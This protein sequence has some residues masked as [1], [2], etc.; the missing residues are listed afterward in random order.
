MVVDTGEDLLRNA[1]FNSVAIGIDHEGVQAISPGVDDSLAIDRTTATDQSLTRM[2]A[3]IKP[4]LV[5]VDGA[6]GEGV[7]GTE[8]STDHFEEVGRTG[9]KYRRLRADRSEE[10][11]VDAS[12]LAQT[13]DVHPHRLLQHRLVCRE[14]RLPVRQVQKN[15][16]CGVAGGKEMVVHGRHLSI[17]ANPGRHAIGR[18]ESHVTV[19]AVGRWGFR[20]APGVDT[21]TGNATESP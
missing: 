6:L 16:K 21:M 5:A 11:A 2:H 7:P 8:I 15:R 18:H 4:D 17:A 12:V 13:D 20:P 10:G 14:H 9:T 1:V 3:H 19:V